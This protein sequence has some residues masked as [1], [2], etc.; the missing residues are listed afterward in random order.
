MNKK[1]YLG[2]GIFFVAVI[3]RLIPHYPNF[4]PIESIALFGGTYLAYKHLSYILPLVALYITD[5]ILNNTILRSYFPDQEGF[6]WF[7][8][9]MIYSAVAIIGIA[10]IGKYIRK[11]IKPTTV[12]LGAGASSILFFI[13]SNFGVWI[14]SPLYSKTLLG[15]VECYTMAIP[16]FTNSLLSTLVFSSVLYGIYEIIVNRYFDSASSMA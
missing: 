11:K 5:I 9:Y 12:L 3:S 10:L 1:F 7:S 4:T 2:I 14:S 13:V 15:L 16:F 8:D 6:I